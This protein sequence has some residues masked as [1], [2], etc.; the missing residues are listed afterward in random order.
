MQIQDNRHLLEKAS[1]MISQKAYT[2]VGQA[3]DKTLQDWGLGDIQSED[4]DFVRGRRGGFAG[5]RGVS[6]LEYSAW[7]RYTQ[8]VP[9]S[10]ARF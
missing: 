3:I 9:Y 2:F 1:T 10:V 4:G 6:M 5:E 8:R 7:M